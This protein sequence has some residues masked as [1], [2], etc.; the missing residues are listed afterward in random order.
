LASGSLLVRDPDPGLLG[1]LAYPLLAF[2]VLTSQLFLLL[3]A[4]RR[5]F[6]R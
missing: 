1:T 4:I 5:R 6:K 3:F 2:F